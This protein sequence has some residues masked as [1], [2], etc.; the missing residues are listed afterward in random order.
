MKLVVAHA[1]LGIQ[2]EE[3][4]FRAQFGMGAA[5]NG[6]DQPETRIVPGGIILGAGVA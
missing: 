3:L 1:G 5:R 4:L 6:I 2:A